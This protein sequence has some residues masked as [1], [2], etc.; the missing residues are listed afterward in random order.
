ME[1]VDRERFP[2]LA[3]CSSTGIEPVK[4]GRSEVR[5]SG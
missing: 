2:L 1:A 3:F 4:I 5:K